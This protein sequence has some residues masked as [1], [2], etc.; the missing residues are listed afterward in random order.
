[1]KRKNAF[2]L[3]SLIVGTLGF[4]F[5]RVLYG[6]FILPMILGLVA[7]ILGLVGIYQDRNDTLAKI[8]VITGVTVLILTF[9]AIYIWLVWKISRAPYA[10]LA[11][12]K[13]IL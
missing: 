4:V 10:G 5:G 6:F 1:M 8:G 7:I 13:I 11:L 9:T 2:G 3:I 12:K